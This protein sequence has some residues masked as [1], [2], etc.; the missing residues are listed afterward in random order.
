MRFL[1]V[2][3]SWGGLIKKMSEVKKALKE[4]LENLELGGLLRLGSDTTLR[5]KTYGVPGDSQPEMLAR[6]KG[7]LE[8][9]KTSEDG[10]SIVRPGTCGEKGKIYF[11]AMVYNLAEGEKNYPNQCEFSVR[12]TPTIISLLEGTS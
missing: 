1:R 9:A 2:V 8:I 5:V 3:G 10:Y 7:E 12:G 4:R 6:Y 11:Q